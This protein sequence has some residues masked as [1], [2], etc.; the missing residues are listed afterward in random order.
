MNVHSSQGGIFSRTSF[1]DAI[2]SLGGRANVPTI[3]KNLGIKGVEGRRKVYAALGRLM[4][5]GYV[6]KHKEQ[7]KL[8]EYAVAHGQQEIRFRAANGRTNG[9]A[10]GHKTERVYGRK[11]FKVKHSGVILATFTLLEG[12]RSNFGLTETDIANHLNVPK[13]TA[14][15][16]L[17]WLVRKSKAM[18]AGRNNGEVAYTLVKGATPPSKGGDLV[19]VAKQVVGNGSPIQAGIQAAVGGGAASVRQAIEA[20]FDALVAVETALNRN[21]QEKEGLRQKVSELM[22]RFAS[23]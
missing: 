19:A 11:T 20:A 14:R 22:E 16:T 7:G 1:S 15:S 18:T 12:N 9:H 10:A 6:T 13:K 21:E 3:C 17:Q 2:K 8:V 23:V 5:D 4:R